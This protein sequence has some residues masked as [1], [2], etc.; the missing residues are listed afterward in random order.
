MVSDS[1][2]ELLYFS[3]LDLVNRYLSVT[4]YLYLYF[5]QLKPA[6][7]LEAAPCVEQQLEI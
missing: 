7:E 4:L 5:D 2:F 6:V 1:F 3:G